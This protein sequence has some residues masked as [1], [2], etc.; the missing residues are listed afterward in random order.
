VLGQAFGP[1][2]AE[3]QFQLPPERKA[4]LERAWG[5]RSRGGAIRW[6]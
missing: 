4:A 1:E 6:S 5:E 3:V 2:G